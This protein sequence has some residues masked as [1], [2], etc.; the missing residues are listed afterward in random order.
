MQFQL[1]K[2]S[3]LTWWVV[4]NCIVWKKPWNKVLLPIVTAVLRCVF[5]TS[6]SGGVHFSLLD[7]AC[8]LLSL[9]ACSSR[10]HNANTERIVS[11]KFKFAKCSMNCGVNAETISQS[12]RPYLKGERVLMIHGYLS[13]L[14][15]HPSVDLSQGAPLCFAKKVNFSTRCII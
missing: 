15:A 8:W 5:V 2:S 3:F 9:T 7:A 14:R 12:L 4:P 10:I 11:F 13:W 1:K 6:C